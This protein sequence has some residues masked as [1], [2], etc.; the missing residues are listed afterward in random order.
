MAIESPPLNC[1]QL[2]ASI[3]NVFGIGC[4]FGGLAIVSF[5]RD[6]SWSKGGFPPG[7]LAATLVITGVSG[8]YL[9]SRVNSDRNLYFVRFFYAI[10][11]VAALTFST[12]ACVQIA[13]ESDKAASVPILSLVFSV[14]LV[15]LGIFNLWGT[16]SHRRQYTQIQ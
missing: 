6:M 8:A 2:S 16:F 10:T 11:T 3:V 15:A 9:S 7:F 4:G 5:G 13:T 12:I 14:I 1:A